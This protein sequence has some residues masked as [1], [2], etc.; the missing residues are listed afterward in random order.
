MSFA[1]RYAEALGGSINIIATEVGKGSTVRFTLPNPILTRSNECAPDQ[2]H[3]LLAS[4]KYYM[5]PRPPPWDAVDRDIALALGKFGCQPVQAAEQADLI[6]QDAGAGSASE[7]EALAALQGH[8]CLLRLVSAAAARNKAFIFSSSGARAER[9]VYCHL[10]LYKKRVQTSMLALGQALGRM[11]PD[12]KTAT[13]ESA[14]ETAI[15]TAK[16]GR[17]QV[18]LP[19]LVAFVS[20]M[21]R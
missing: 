9:I 5:C 1:K 13:V 3:E 10:P 8:Q 16:R 12:S 2:H 20:G 4:R 11:H 14:K 18:G 21:Q 6:V 17:E 15:G 7:E 19:A